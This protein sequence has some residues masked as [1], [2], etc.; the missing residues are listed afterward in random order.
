MV[1]QNTIY[2]QIQ[3]T[4]LLDN[5]AKKVEV[6]AWLDGKD[7]ACKNGNAI[8]GDAFTVDLS[9]TIPAASAE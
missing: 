4:I 5:S 2:N 9:F 7:S 8:K 3:N 6:Y 1:V